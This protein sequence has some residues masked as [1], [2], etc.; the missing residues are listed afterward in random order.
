M[1][2]MIYFHIFLHVSCV[3]R[4]KLYYKILSNQYI[5]ESNVIKQY[6]GKLKMEHKK[7]QPENLRLTYRIKTLYEMY[8]ELKH[9]AEY[10]QRKSEV[11]IKHEKQSAITR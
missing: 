5:N 3:W 10:L 7:Q 4:L 8:L 9:T 2:L 6:I 1:K 11:I